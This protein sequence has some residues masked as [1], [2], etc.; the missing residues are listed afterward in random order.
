[1]NQSILSESA[2][3][4]SKTYFVDV[5]RAARAKSLV[6][7]GAVCPSRSSLHPE[8]FRVSSQESAI[9]FYRVNSDTF[10]CQCED[11]QKHS[12][13]IH[14]FICKHILAC[15][16][17]MKYHNELRRQTETQMTG[18]QKFD[19]FVESLGVKRLELAK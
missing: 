3:R 19:L 13:P 1:M 11:W 16:I 14:G 7:L 10:V 9:K 18:T 12:D 8:L 5:G 17:W 15:L 4:L 6:E 2:E